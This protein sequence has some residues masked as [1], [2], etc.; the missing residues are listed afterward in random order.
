[1]ISEKLLK[2][3][4]CPKTGEPLVLHSDHLQCPACGDKFHFKPGDDYIDMRTP[5]LA[6]KDSIY[7]NEEFV[8]RK[9]LMTPGPPFLSGGI[10]NWVLNRMMH[11]K[12]GDDVL[13]GGCGPGRYILWNQKSGAHFVGIDQE[14]YFAKETAEVSDLVQGHLH[15]MPFAD[16][17]F[18]QIICLDVLEHMAL[19]DIS[20]FLK[21]SE[22]I[23]KKDGRLFI[24]TNS[25][26]SS[27]LAPV[28]RFRQRITA[29]FVKWGK[30][31]IKMEKESKEDH[32]NA[33]KT[34]R[35]LIEL[36]GESG[37]ILSDSAYYNPVIMGWVEN[38]FI[39]IA[40]GHA[41]GRIRNRKHKASG[42]NQILTASNAKVLMKEKVKRKGAAYFL[43]WLLTQI[44]KLDMIFFSSIEGGQF[45]LV[46]NKNS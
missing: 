42:R 17:A 24:Y 32:I 13:D 9:G 8:I 20:K 2:M 16:G 1:M 3:M 18:D 36:A 14:P 5:G 38:L 25:V 40:E 7:G 43:F 27:A 22:K 34:R 37:L 4:R 12:E 23:L 44:M 15:Y 33:I 26:E 11:F 41:N 31:D 19:E 39:K 45:F 10:K 30:I 6:Q 28:I 21:T 46:F 35:Q 29:L